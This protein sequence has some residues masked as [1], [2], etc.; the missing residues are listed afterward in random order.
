ML[1]VVDSHFITRFAGIAF[2]DFI[3]TTCSFLNL[4][5]SSELS[6]STLASETMTHGQERNLEG[7]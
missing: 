2:P 4:F 7:N 3:S 1:K 5:I 6:F